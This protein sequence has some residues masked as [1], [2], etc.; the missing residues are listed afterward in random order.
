MDFTYYQPTEIRFGKGKVN[1]VGEAAAALGKTALVVTVPLFPEIQTGFDKMVKSIKDAGLPVYHYDRVIPNPTVQ[2]MDAGV[3]FAREKGVD[4]VIGYGGGSSMDTAK[5]IAVGATH[6]GSVWDYLFFKKQPTEATL[7]II[8]VTTTSGTGSQVTQVSVMTD[9]SSHSK[10]AIFN[11]HVFPRISIVDFELMKTIPAKITASTGF[12]AFAHAFEAYIH[13]MTNPYVEMLALKAMSLVAGHLPGLV[14]DG[15]WEKG[16]EAMA[17]ADTLAGLCI[18]SAGVTLPHG[19]GMIISGYC[20]HVMHGESL[21]V[22]YPEFV[23]ITK[24][25][26]VEK[27]AAMTRIL[28][29]EFA[30]ASDEEAVDASGDVIDNFL[31]KID[32]W[33]SF[34]SLNVPKEQLKEISDHCHDLPDYSNN[35]Y[36]ASIDEIYAILGKSYKR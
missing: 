16:R 2:S 5:A 3:E 36:V 14:A 27:F 35:P 15:Y 25:H 30:H 26:A 1:E 9:S 33:I 10:S 34:E 19:I 32:M 21:A 13:K 28:A 8:A 20:P 31:K 12:D 22:V 6:E 4:V 17:L 24:S 7:P 29:P 11:N 23:Q 18:A